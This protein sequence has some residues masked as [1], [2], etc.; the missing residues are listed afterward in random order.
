MYDTA[1]TPGRATP[2][3]AD[4]A[5]QKHAY[6]NPANDTNP[7]TTVHP[8]DTPGSLRVAYLHKD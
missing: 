3:A 6:T 4:T 8:E 2:S 7:T 5:L 1:R